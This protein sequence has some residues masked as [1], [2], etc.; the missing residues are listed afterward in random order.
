[1]IRKKDNS[2]RLCVD[3]RWLNA[4]TR[5]APVPMQNAE[6]LLAQVSEAKFFIKLDLTKGFYQEEEMKEESKRYTAFVTEGPY[7]F[8]VLPFGLS[9]NPSIFVRLRKVLGNLKNDAH[10]YDDILVYS[11]TFEEHLTDQKKGIKQ[12]KEIRTEC[13]AL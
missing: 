12:F 8:K 3:C 13:Q 9:N 4:I 2:V 5:I 10:Y 6:Y 1:M 11:N 7:H